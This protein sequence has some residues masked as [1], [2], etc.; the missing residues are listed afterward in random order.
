MEIGTK[1]ID[2]IDKLK[3][4]RSNQKEV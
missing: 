4:M 2:I 3:S 1:I